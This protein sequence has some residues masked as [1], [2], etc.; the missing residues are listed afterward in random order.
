MTTTSK[1]PFIKRFK[2]S[3][4]QYVFDVNSNRILSVDPEVYE[5]LG[6][7]Q[8]LTYQNILQKH[9]PRFGRNKVGK[10]VK[11][12]EQAIAREKL[13]LSSRPQKLSNAGLSPEEFQE[14]YNYRLRQIV[15]DITEHCNLRCHYCS[16]EWNQG[17]RN[18]RRRRMA[19]QTALKAIDFLHA[20]SGQ[21]EKRSLSFY[22]GDPLLEFDLIQRCVDY[23]RNEFSSDCPRFNVTT[24]GVLLDRNM[25]EY[26]ARHRF[27]VTVSVDGPRSVHDRHRVD[28][29]RKGSYEKSVL[30][31]RRLFEAY[32]GKAADLISINMVITPPYDL[33]I[34]QEL[35][36]EQRWL[37]RDISTQPNYV[38]TEFTNF[39]E[40]Y[41][42]DPSETVYR[43]SRKRVF[44]TF[45]RECIA[46][47]PRKTPLVFSFI[48]PAMLTFYN[49][50]VYDPP[51]TLYPLNGC[52]IPGNRRV[53]GSTDGKL[54]LCEKADGCPPL[55]SVFSGYDSQRMQELVDTYDQESLQDCQRCWAVGICS[56]CFADALSDGNFDPEKK[57]R[58]CRGEREKLTSQLKTY[59][60][61]LEKNPKAFDYMKTIT[62]S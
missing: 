46:G 55:G 18:Y 61:I 1:R 22:G 19:E 7:Y 41:D 54:W 53:F 16:R 56:L 5:V 11:D 44:S 35:W 45:R 10:A 57:R 26:F 23:A 40:K 14:V 59:C 12:I 39:L 28:S 38:N 43:R 37:P 49:R 32:D 29:H 60:S 33:D 34:L 17:L 20:H 9:S 21:S 48:E 47:T 4:R 58:N 6:D 36:E 13:F 50:R 2:T 52:C 62:V 42:C 15:L 25:A 31:L 30:G 27:G 24:N 51:R 8:H 3:R